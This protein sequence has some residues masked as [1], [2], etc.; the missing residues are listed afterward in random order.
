MNDFKNFEMKN[1]LLLIL[2]I[3]LLVSCGRNESYKVTKDGV[4]LN[5]DGH[6]LNV[7]VY[8]DNIIRVTCSAMDTMPHKS[9]MTV[10]KN[11]LPTRWDYSDSAGNIIISTAR[12]KVSI[13]KKTGQVSYFDQNGRAVLREEEGGGRTLEPAEV[14]GE[15]TYH[16]GQ[17]FYSPED[18]ALYGLG[19][20]QNHLMNYK[21]YDVDLWQDNMEVVVPFLVSNRGYGILWDNNSRSRFGSMKDPEA[22]PFTDFTS[23]KGNAG[24]LTVSCYVNDSLVVTKETSSLH[25][26]VTDSILPEPSGEPTAG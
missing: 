3:T 4:S 1:G 24:K 2:G 17:K 12:L 25:F 8:R 7:S 26:S 5:V 15:N 18:E 23:A 16:V 22:I 9:L 11:P 21:G 10:L 19:Q 14:M 13:N 6:F 20:H